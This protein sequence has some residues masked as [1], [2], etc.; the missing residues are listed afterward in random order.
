MTPVE[1]KAPHAG[2]QFVV[3]AKNQ[4]EYVPLPAY[5]DREGLA[6]TEWELSAEDLARLL[7]GGRVRLWVWTFGQPLQPVML[8]VVE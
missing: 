5:V 2:A 7:N 8:D 3:Y 1:P 4:P 6:L